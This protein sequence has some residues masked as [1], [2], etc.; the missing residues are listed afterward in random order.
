VH[1]VAQCPRDDLAAR[2]APQLL[3]DVVD[4]GLDRALG[5][6]QLLGD[7]GV[8]PAPGDELEDLALARVSRP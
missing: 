3:L 4:V 7:L 8:G 5:D 2:S 1:G 6:E